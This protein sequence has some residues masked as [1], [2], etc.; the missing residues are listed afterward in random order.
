M[1]GKFVGSTWADQSPVL[2]YCVVH[3][4]SLSLLETSA[5]KLLSKLLMRECTS[6]WVF[7]WNPSQK[8]F[9]HSLQTYGFTPLCR[10]TC[11][12][13]C[14]LWL[15]FFSQILQ[16]SQVPSLCNSSRCRFS[17]PNHV[18]RSEQCLHEYGFA[19]V[20]IRK[21]D[22]RSMFVLNIFTQKGHRYGLLSVCTLRLCFSKPLDSQK[23]LLHSEHLYGLSPVWTLV[24]LFRCPE[25]L[26]SLSHTWHLY[27]LTPLW[28]LLCCTRWFDLINSLL[29][30]A[31][32]NVFCPALLC[33]TSALPHCF[34]LT[35]GRHKHRFFLDCGLLRTC[36]LSFLTHLPV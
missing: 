12:S 1:T 24:C 11:I 10:R 28:I 32:S 34:S 13:K 8:R 14:P 16:T 35:L 23:L 29:Q 31:H 7:N 27:S 25:W 15:N 19:S 36:K 21:W 4:P 17:C 6:W 3:W 5:D 20:W 33:I 26:N 22:F 2:S 30:T 9:G 18:K